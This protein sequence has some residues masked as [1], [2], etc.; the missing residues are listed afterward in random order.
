ML[1]IANVHKHTYIFMLRIY[2]CI[3]FKKWVYY[4]IKEV[5]IV[6]RR[7]F[8][9]SPYFTHGHYVTKHAIYDM[10]KRFI[11]KGELGYNLSKKPIYKSKP[12]FDL[13]HRLFYIRMDDKKTL[14]I[15]NP[16]NKTVCSVRKYHDKELRKR[17]GATN[18]EKNK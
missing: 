15:I 11:S 4:G 16:S 2:I 18:Y 10:N 14:T 1:I 9:K 5:I 12:Q 3:S 17:K 7:V 8:P 6:R 13:L